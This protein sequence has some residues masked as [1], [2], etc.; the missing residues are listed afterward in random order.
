MDSNASDGSVYCTDD[1]SSTSS[2]TDDSAF[3]SIHSD[4]DDSA[5][6]RS[7]DVE[8]QDLSDVDTSDD[9]DATVDM[10]NNPAVTPTR[11]PSLTDAGIAALQRKIKNAEERARASFESTVERI[12]EKRYVTNSD[13]ENQDDSDVDDDQSHS[14]AHQCPDARGNV[15]F[16]DVVTTAVTA[17][18]VRGRSP[19]DPV[20]ITADAAKKMKSVIGQLY[21]FF[22]IVP[23][24][25]RTVEFRQNGFPTALTAV[26]LQQWTRFMLLRTDRPGRGQYPGLKK[27]TVMYHC[28]N[29]IVELFTHMGVPIPRRTKTIILAE[30]Q[31]G[32]HES[33]CSIDYVLLTFSLHCVVL[34][35]AC[36]V[37]ERLLRDN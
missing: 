36:S 34:C 18:A 20:E 6:P 29:N 23:E 19:N 21:R 17:Q 8:M 24:I 3:V 10:I 35:R 32:K 22:R 25:G 2:D 9:I 16:R 12:V 33:G 30:I 37:G 27:A 4:T 15:Y 1:E 5:S 11:P 13:D 7:T 14:S 26:Q 28:R 31:V